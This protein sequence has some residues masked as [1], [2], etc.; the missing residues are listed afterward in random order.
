MMA[1]GLEGYQERA[2]TILS[3]ADRLRRGI[4]NIPD[5][6]LIGNGRL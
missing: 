4:R 1:I 2:N 3:A 6:E 5:L